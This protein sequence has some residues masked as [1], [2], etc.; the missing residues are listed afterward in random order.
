MKYSEMRRWRAG[1]SCLLLLLLL[2]DCKPA[3]SSPA[4]EAMQ[5]IQRWA[6]AFSESNVDAIVGLYAPDASFFGTGSK[7][8][9]STPDQVRSYFEAGLQRDRPRGAELLEHSVQVVSDDVVI[10][11]GKDRVSGTKDGSVYHAEGRVTFVLQKRAS[12]WQIVH[13]HRSAMPTG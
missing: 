6:L 2:C 13:F 8:L 1:L 5:V 7:A 11:T 10:V 3:P 4:E 12:S 9:V